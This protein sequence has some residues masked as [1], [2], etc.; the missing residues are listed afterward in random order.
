M[1]ECY[2]VY[3]SLQRLDD[4]FLKKPL[5]EGALAVKI[6][7]GDRIALTSILERWGFK[8][9]ESALRFCIAVLYQAEKDVVYIDKDGVRTGLSPDESLVI[10]K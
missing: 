4:N 6:D 7:N 9:E 1:R 2:D 3:M 5:G 8:D 10:K